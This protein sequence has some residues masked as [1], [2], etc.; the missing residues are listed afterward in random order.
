MAVVFAVNKK[1][2]CDPILSRLLRLLSLLTAIYDV[3]LVA[4]HL[5]GLYNTVAD[6]LFRNNLEL[7]RSSHPQAS[8]I[9]T[10][11]PSSLQELLFNPSIATNSQSWMQ[12]LSNNL[13]EASHSPLAHRTP[14]PSG[15]I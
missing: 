3:T 13:Q 7:L 14:P 15:D 11:I 1:S 10:I 12:R 2:A 4:R 6:A 8:P 9:P 5:P